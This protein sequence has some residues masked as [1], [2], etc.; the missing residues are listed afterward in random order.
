MHDT[1]DDRP[2]AVVVNLEEQ[3]SVWPATRD[4][5]AGWRATGFTGSR[6]ECLAHIDE[7]WTDMRPLSLRH[8]S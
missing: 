6:A 5:P 2:H 4:V 8:A 1:T 3:Y 7:V